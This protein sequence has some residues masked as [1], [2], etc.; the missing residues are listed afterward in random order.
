V[1]LIEALQGK[2]DVPIS[3]ASL[4]GKGYCHTDLLG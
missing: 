3:V 1:E 2:R 4:S